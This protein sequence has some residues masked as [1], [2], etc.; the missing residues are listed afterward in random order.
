MTQARSAADSREKE[1][2]N[3]KQSSRAHCHRRTS[4]KQNDKLLSVL[5]WSIPRVPVCYQDMPIRSWPDLKRRLCSLYIWRE[6]KRTSTI[7][8]PNQAKAE[9]FHLSHVLPRLSTPKAQIFKGKAKAPGRPEPDT[10]P[11][12]SFLGQSSL[13]KFHLTVHMEGVRGENKCHLGP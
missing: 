8:V 3:K 10:C 1:N 12:S 6:T 9:A 7:H 13:W 2:M 4:G 11:H 5:W